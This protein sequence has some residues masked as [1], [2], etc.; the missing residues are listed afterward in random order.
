MRVRTNALYLATENGT[1]GSLVGPA[2]TLGELPSRVSWRVTQLACTKRHAGHGLC[3]C[4]GVPSGLALRQVA[5]ANQRRAVEQHRHGHPIPSEA[6]HTAAGRR[7]GRRGPAPTSCG[8]RLFQGRR[9]F[10]LG[11]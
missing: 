6:G 11:A 5:L 7:A 9:E 1:G 10:C 3:R 4:V 8:N 2:D